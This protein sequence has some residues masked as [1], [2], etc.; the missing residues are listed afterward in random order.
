[1]IQSRTI[2]VTEEKM[3]TASMTILVPKDLHRK[4]KF[5]ALKAEKPMTH[6]II[7]AMKDF[8]KEIEENQ[9]KEN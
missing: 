7:S 4:F 8:I 6:I 2:S 9:K 3:E 5:A 1:M